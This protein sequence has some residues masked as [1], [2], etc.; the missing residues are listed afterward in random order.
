[1]QVAGFSWGMPFVGIAI[2]TVHRIL[3]ASMSV[4]AMLFGKYKADCIAMLI[5]WCN[6]PGAARGCKAHQL[7]GKSA[8]SAGKA[9]LAKQQCRE[10]AYLGA[11]GSVA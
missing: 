2:L 5:G 10:R 1:M 3:L 4:A 11:W 7:A 9:M 8:F 6:E